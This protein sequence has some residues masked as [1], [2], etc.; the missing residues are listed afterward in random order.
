MCRRQRSGARR[1]SRGE[2]VEVYPGRVVLQRKPHGAGLNHVG[3]SPAIHRPATR[4]TRE[5][6]GWH[7]AHVHRNPGAH[8]QTGPTWPQNSHGRQR[9]QDSTTARPHSRPPF[10]LRTNR[11][12]SPGRRNRPHLRRNRLEGESSDHGAGV[13]ELTGSPW[14]SSRRRTGSPRAAGDKRRAR[15]RGNGSEPTSRGGRSTPSRGRRSG[16]VGA[17]IAGTGARSGS[18]PVHPVSSLCSSSRRR[19]RAGILRRALNTLE[20]GAELEAGGAE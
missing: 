7:R 3:P 16:P 11:A 5:L 4:R 18:S 15:G 10:K 12:S 20:L 19:A 9:P 14:S 2:D 17:R 8:G 1:L 6:G 13:L